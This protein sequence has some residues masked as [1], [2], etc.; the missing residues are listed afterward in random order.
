MKQKN[1]KKT[2]KNKKNF[3]G[4]TDVENCALFTVDFSELPKQH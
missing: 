3:S 1:K 2:K 4:S